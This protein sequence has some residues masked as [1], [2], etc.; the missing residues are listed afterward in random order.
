M[1]QPEITTS[2]L[3]RTDEEWEAHDAQVRAATERAQARDVARQYKQRMQELASWGVPAK[4]L[5]LVLPES[6]T[7]DETPALLAVARDSGLLV[8]LSGGVGCGKTTAASW[9][10][11]HGAHKVMPYLKV[12][13]PCFI[14]A[15]WVERHSRY[16]HEVMSRLEQARALVL[17]D[18]GMEYADAK[19]NFLADIDAVIDTRYRNM[20][21]TVITT[22][23]KADDFKQRYG[24]RF[25]DR[26]V[27]GGCFCN[28]NG[29]SLRRG[30]GG[31]R[32]KQTKTLSIEAPNRAL[33]Q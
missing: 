1:G 9:W 14:T 17:D 28:V 13:P 19:G 3:H 27:E 5:S 25:R 24:R 30:K 7:L 6:G 11:A 33:A 26:V 22:N 32:G 8:V 31:R 16:D 15:P 12:R 2:L 18:L 10:L 21:P 4:D 20:L 29:P 23:L